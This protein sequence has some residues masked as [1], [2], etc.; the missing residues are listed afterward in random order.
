[1]KTG[2][3]IKWSIGL[4]AFG[5]FA[6]CAVLYIMASR[7]P[8]DYHPIV[9]G[10]EQKQE[11]LQSLKDKVEQFIRLAGEVGSLEKPLTPTGNARPTQNKRFQMT[12]NQ[13][14]LNQ[15]A[16]TISEKFAD[17]LR[18]LGMSQPAV[19]IGNNRLTFYSYWDRYDK[20]VG[21]DIGF[22]FN[23]D[24]KMTIQLDRARIGTLPM[25]EQAMEK[26]KT[27]LISKLQDHVRSIGSGGG[28]FAGKPMGLF[29]AAAGQIADAMSGRPVTLDIRQGFGNVRINNIT[30]QNNIA[31]IDVVSLPPE[32]DQSPTSNNPKTKRP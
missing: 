17:A 28:Q 24:A 20:V 12:V 5:I 2:R 19:A 25:P 6:T 30:M 23:Q 18:E 22:A 31:T 7:V 13:K 26:H 29:N 9:M 1:M 32:Q 16:A 21:L 3:I 27:E 10:A 15:W 14:E 11:A 8:D 4:L